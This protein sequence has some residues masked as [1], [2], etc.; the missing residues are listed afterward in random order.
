MY[1]RM[2]TQPT[3]WEGTGVHS[4]TTQRVRLEPIPVTEWTRLLETMGAFWILRRRAGSDAHVWPVTP[5]FLVD[6]H[7]ATALGQADRTVTTVEHLL[8]ALMGLRIGGVWIDVDGDEIPILDGSAQPFVRR[9]LPLLRDTDFPWPRYALH[10][11]IDIR[12]ETAWLQATPSDRWQV[13]YTIVFDHPLIGTQRWSGVIESVDFVHEIAPARTF[14]FMRD[15]F[16]L[17]RQGRARGASPENT[18]ILT[19]HGLINPPLRFPD[20]FVRHKVLD[21]MG[22]LALLGGGWPRAH[23]R[24]YRGGH[25]L[26]IEFVRHIWRARHHA[27]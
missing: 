4:G 5:K 12:Q 14:G 18:L 15:A 25:R 22:D 13:E 23:I 16:H 2:L 27:S 19:D 6:T 20:E 1:T 11:P 17:L 21:L 8:A 3:S 9:L 10:T 7:H 24:I 26:H